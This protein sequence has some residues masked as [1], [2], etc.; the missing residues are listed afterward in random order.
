MTTSRRPMNTLVWQAL[1]GVAGLAIWQWGYDLRASVPWL[2][3]LLLE[4]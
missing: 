1:I 2:G 3:P 4:P